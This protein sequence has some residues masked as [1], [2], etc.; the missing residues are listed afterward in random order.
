[1]VWNNWKSFKTLTFVDTNGK[2]SSAVKFSSNEEDTKSL[3]HHI[4][5]SIK[6]LNCDDVNQQMRRR[7]TIL[8]R[9][10]KLNDK[11]LRKRALEREMK[12]HK[13]S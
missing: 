10:S 5:T 1:M 3:F 9:N 6:L 8:S 13:I 7:M 4:R 12:V 2:S 11:L